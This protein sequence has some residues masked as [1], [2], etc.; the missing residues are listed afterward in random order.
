MGGVTSC[1]ESEEAGPLQ[2]KIEQKPE[3]SIA[4]I[5]RIITTIVC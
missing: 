5:K 1:P 2:P 4:T 3:S